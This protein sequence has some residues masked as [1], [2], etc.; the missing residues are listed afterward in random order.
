MYLSQFSLLR[1]EGAKEE[2]D[3]TEKEI[4]L[5]RKEVR[6]L[7][8]LTVTEASDPAYQKRLRYLQNRVER[9]LKVVRSAP[10]RVL[11]E[12]EVERLMEILGMAYGLR[13]DRNDENKHDIDDKTAKDLEEILRA[14]F[15]GKID[16]EIMPMFL[17]SPQSL[18]TRR[19]D[20][21]VQEDGHSLT[22]ELVASWNH[23]FIEGYIFGVESRT[24]VEQRSKPIVEL[25]PLPTVYD[26]T[27]FFNGDVGS[28]RMVERALRKAVNRGAMEKGRVIFVSNYSSEEMESEIKKRLGEKFGFKLLETLGPQS[29]IEIPAQDPLK[30]R[31]IHTHLGTEQFQLITDNASRWAMEMFSLVAIW[32]LVGWDKVK[33]IN[34]ELRRILEQE[35]KAQ[36]LLAL[37]A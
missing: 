25:A 21:H 32:E 9:K 4:K 34:G 14:L 24:L 12:D 17:D 18:L 8:Y 5:F 20:I 23:K 36:E 11:G 29:Y 1:F 16:V 28:S 7:K 31:T 27:S 13:E 10:E 37:H 26:L 22:K 2:L 30:L 33:R 35:L 6:S 3:R 15:K 19:F